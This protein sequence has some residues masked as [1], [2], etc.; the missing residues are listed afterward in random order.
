MPTASIMKLL[1]PNCQRPIPSDDIELAAGWAKC[2]KCDEIFKLAEI[3]PGYGTSAAAAGP[4][5]PPERPFDA[6][7][8]VDRTPERMIVVIPA[9]G[10]R[11]AT[12]GLLGFAI[13]WLGFIAFWTAGALGVFFNHG[14]V[15]PQNALFAAFSTPFWLVGIGMLAGVVWSARGTL[16]VYLDASTLY[17]ESRCLFARW[18][19][20]I[21]RAEVQHARKGVVKVRNNENS[22]YT[23]YSVEIIYTK[24]SY[25][26]SCN[27]ETE[28][29]WL[30]G[31]IND[32]LKTVPYR[33]GA[34][35]G[36]DMLGTSD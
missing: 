12:W 17:T 35:A 10:M 16:R 22:T 18:R 21:D 19:K 13:F 5:A 23:P 33:P 28:Q 2:R 25:R 24:G 14:R 20:T 34:S 3:L 15:R 31:E 1:C 36:W 26:L 27:S 11:A 8:V 9:N 30:I 4:T 7:A 32:F 6:W 29:D